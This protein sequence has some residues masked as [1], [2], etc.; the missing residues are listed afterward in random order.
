MC[1]ENGEKLYKKRGYDD[2]HATELQFMYTKCS[3]DGYTWV[4]EQKDPHKA[5]SHHLAGTRCI[6][7]LQDGRLTLM[8]FVAVLHENVYA[9]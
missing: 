6:L 9:S 7:V 4:V 8:M 3:E 1:T 2:L 5:G